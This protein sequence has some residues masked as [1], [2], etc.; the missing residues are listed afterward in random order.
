[1]FSFNEIEKKDGRLENRTRLVWG[2]QPSMIMLKIA[3]PFL[4]AV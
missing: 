4:T 3:E 2:L 1:M